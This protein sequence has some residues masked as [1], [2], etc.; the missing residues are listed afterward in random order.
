M[1]E[2]CQILMQYNPLV[3]PRGEIKNQKGIF[4]GR[5][6]LAPTYPG[7]QSKKTILFMPQEQNLHIRPPALMALP[8]NIC[9]K[10]KRL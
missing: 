9:D 4:G 3:N 6:G 8:C 5:W 7:S 1:P 10:P 2:A